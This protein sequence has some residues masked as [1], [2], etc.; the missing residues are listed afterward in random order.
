MKHLEEHIMSNIDGIKQMIRDKY[1][2][3]F[4]IVKQFKLHERQMKNVVEIIMK[5]R[6][7]EGSGE[8][9]IARKPIANGYVCASCESYLGELKNDNT[10]YLAW[11]K[12][13]SSTRNGEEFRMGN[14]FSRILGMVSMRKEERDLPRVRSRMIKGMKG[15]EGNWSGVMED[16]EE[17]SARAS[18]E[19]TFMNKEVKM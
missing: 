18:K 1:M 6:E 3:R 4:D 11:N 2:E 5:R 13:P 7:E 12:Y 15:K 16:G 19:G 10:E 14:G 17:G 8:W 9:L